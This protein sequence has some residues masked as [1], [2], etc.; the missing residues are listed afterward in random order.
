MTRLVFII[1]TVA[2]GDRVVAF[3]RI[4]ILLALR[5]VERLLKCLYQLLFKF[6]EIFIRLIAIYIYQALA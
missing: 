6:I 5:Q 4:A 2:I 1:V 3:D